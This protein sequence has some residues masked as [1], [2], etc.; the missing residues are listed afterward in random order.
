MNECM[1]EC[2]FTDM[3]TVPREIAWSGVEWSSLAQRMLGGV[4]TLHEFLAQR[5]LRG[6]FTLHAT[7]L[8][9]A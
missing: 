3:K 7:F 5:I 1:N 6:V 2:V 4:F 8:R 9:C